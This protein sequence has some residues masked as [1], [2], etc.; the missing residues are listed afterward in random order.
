MENGRRRERYQFWIFHE[1]IYIF[2]PQFWKSNHYPLEFR[3]RERY[4]N[5][6]SPLLKQ[7]LYR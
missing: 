5:K 3:R 6:T 4:R 1:K 2:Y 7:A